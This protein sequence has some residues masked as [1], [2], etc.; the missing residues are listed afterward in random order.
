MMLSASSSYPKLSHMHHSISLSDA[1][2]EY[3]AANLLDWARFRR[4]AFPCHHI[5]WSFFSRGRQFWAHLAPG[6][7][8]NYSNNRILASNW[9]KLQLLVFQCK[10]FYLPLY[11][12]YFCHPLMSNFQ[13][14]KKQFVCLF[15]FCQGSFWN[16]CNLGGCNYFFSKAVT[17]ENSPKSSHR[18]ILKT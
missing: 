14:T 18:P 17:S 11:S 6:S 3:F 15:H 5:T 7:E 2:C 13:L 16:C 4:R 10:A 9:E 1:G 12:A 8:P